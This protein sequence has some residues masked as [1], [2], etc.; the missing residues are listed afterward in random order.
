MKLQLSINYL[1]A[2]RSM[3][4]HKS[5]EFK[6]RRA[7]ELMYFDARGAIEKFNLLLLTGQI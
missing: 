1:Q 4:K 7:N 3:R 2:E 6:L 5:I